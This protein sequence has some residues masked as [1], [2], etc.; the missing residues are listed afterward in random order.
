MDE[1]IDTLKTFGTQ[2]FK[3]SFF[4]KPVKIEPIKYGKHNLQIGKKLNG[5]V[6]CLDIKESFRGILLGATRSGKTF[7]LRLIGDRYKQIGNDVVYLSDVKNEFWSSNKPLQEK[8][9]DLLLEGE[10]PQKTRV[11]ALRPT[12]FRQIDT[13]LAE[14]NFWYSI[15]GNSL[16]RAD[17]MTL[18]N[19]HE[20]TSNQRT[21]MELIFQELQK[22]LKSNPELQFSTELINQI[23]DDDADIEQRQ[24][25]A[26]KFKFK[27]L[28]NSSF[29]DKKE[30]KSIVTLLKNGFVPAINLENFDSFGKGSF[31]FPEV[32][33]NIVLREIIVARRAKKIKRVLIIIDEA[34]RFIGKNKQTSI[35]DSVLE[36]QDVD[37]RYSVDYLTAWQSFE[38]IPE[39]ILKQGRYIFVPRTADVA[40][41]KSVLISTGQVKNVQ[42]S[43]NKAMELKRQLKQHRFSWVI[44]DRMEGT[45]DLIIPLAPLSHHLETSN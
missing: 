3:D 6:Y 19:A 31:S 8:F 14:R 35:K 29:I 41:I 21:G 40:T 11:V 5:Q 1:R 16:T 28:D 25:V 18:M 13:K 45:L 30:T 10:T 33:L 23:I 20:L 17:F 36:S 4:N 12:F 7:V 38:D 9:H 26:L 34:T 27:P 43:V 32:T 37:T 22:R 24:K 2:Y 15:D 39:R 44:I 42:R